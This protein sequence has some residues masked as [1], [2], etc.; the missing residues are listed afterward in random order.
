MSLDV[1]DN[2]MTYDSLYIRFLATR[3]AYHIALLWLVGVV[4][5]STSK[6]EIENTNQ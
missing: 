2:L 4:S 1:Y 6:A 5:S 3:T